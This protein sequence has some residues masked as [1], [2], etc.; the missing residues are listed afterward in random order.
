MEMM[1]KY[2]VA[3]IQDLDKIIAVKNEAKQRI[4]EEHL[5]VW[6][7]EYPDTSFLKE[8]LENGYGRV[9]VEEDG[10]IAA[11]ACFHPIDTEYPKGSF[12]KE[13]LQSFS[14]VMVGNKYLG[15]HYGAYLI[16]SL[17]EEAKTIPVD[18][19]GIIVDA[20]NVR[21]IGLY[22]KYGFK[23]ESSKQFEYGFFDVYTLF[24]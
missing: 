14:R 3:G 13:N 18:G 19:M 2:R 23:K 1:M 16:E 6:L 24:F 7:G 12:S 11:Y 22:K 4:V 9:I 8:D 21:A 20:C 15:K 10:D 17:I 5:A